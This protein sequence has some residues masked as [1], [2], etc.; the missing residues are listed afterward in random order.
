MHTTKA[1]DK[2]SSGQCAHFRQYTIHA[3]THTTER[4]IQ[5]YTLVDMPQRYAHKRKQCCECERVDSGELCSGVTQTVGAAVDKEI[6]CPY[7]GPTPAVA[8][9]A[10]LYCRL[11]VVESDKFALKDT[12][13]QYILAF[14]VSRYLLVHTTSFIYIYF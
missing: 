11:V 7:I 6:V 4:I 13:K 9:A 1:Y 8:A 5:T 14:F 3:C 10:S 2:Y 12:H